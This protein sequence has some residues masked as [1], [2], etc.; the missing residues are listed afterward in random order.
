MG[1]PEG[2]SAHYVY[3]THSLLIATAWISGVCIMCVWMMAETPC[4]TVLEKIVGLR[5]STKFNVGELE[6][7]G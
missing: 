7:V 6:V 5:R 1:K 3:I 2:S 4:I